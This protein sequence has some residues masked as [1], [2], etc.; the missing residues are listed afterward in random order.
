[1]AATLVRGLDEK[2]HRAAVAACER[3]L[4]LASF[5]TRHQAGGVA[6]TSQCV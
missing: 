2:A 1:M 4:N 6:E 3:R 5:V